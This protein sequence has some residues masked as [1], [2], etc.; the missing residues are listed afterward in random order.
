M[1]KEL[2]LEHE[3]DTG[4]VRILGKSHGVVY[5]IVKN[6]IK[7]RDSFVYEI[8][9]KGRCIGFEVSTKIDLKPFHN[10]LKEFAEEKKIEVIE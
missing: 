10:F 7:L 8:N 5:I 3:K 4:V 2:K 6:Q 9:E 1:K